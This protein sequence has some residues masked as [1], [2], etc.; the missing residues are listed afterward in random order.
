M[1]GNQ[2]RLARVSTLLPLGTAA[3]LHLAAS[4]QDRGS[5]SGVLSALVGL[6]LVHSARRGDLPLPLPSLVALLALVSTVTL[7]LR[8]FPAGAGV[9]TLALALLHAVLLRRWA[10]SRSTHPVG[11]ELRGQGSRQ[12]EVTG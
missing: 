2:Q 4:L 8:P 12:Q 11:V 5:L 10:L 1:V 6:G 9:V 7:G 3:L